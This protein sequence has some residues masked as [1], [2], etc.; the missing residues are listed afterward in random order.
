MAQPKSKPETFSKERFDSALRKLVATP[1]QPNSAK[2]SKR[3]RHAIAKAA[4]ATKKG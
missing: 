2:Q 4:K 1:P 3:K